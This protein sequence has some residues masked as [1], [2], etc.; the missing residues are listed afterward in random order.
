MVTIVTLSIYYK[1]IS[2]IIDCGG[3]KNEIR[4]PRRTKRWRRM[5]EAA[6][7]RRTGRPSYVVTGYKKTTAGPQ[8]AGTK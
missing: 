6:E 8:P 5:S 2:G 1:G 3:Y 7:G 4:R